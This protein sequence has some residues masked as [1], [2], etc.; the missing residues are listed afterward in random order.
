[1]QITDVIV[2]KLFSSGPL[3]AIVTVVLDGVVAI[4]DIKAAKKPNGKLIAVMPTRTDSFGRSRDVVHPVDDGFRQTLENE[5]AK[6]LE[7]Y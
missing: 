3:Y 4:H 2:R 6:K 1:M 5:I 7:V